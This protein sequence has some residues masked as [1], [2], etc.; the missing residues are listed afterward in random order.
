MNV[1]HLELFYHVARH[2]GVSAAARHMP[3][4]IQQPAI[5]AQILQLED[6][7]GVTLFHRRP[8]K[9]T[10][11]G[12]VLFKY[13]E[14]FFDG[15]AEVGDRLRGA[16]EKRVRIAMPEI[17]QRDYLPA[18]LVRMRKRVPGFQFTLTTGRID[19][20]E[21]ML[22]EQHIDIGFASLNTKRSEDLRS[23]LLIRLPLVL[24]VAKNSRFTRADE[25]I[26]KE[27]IDVPLITI[28]GADPLCRLF[29]EGL[30]KQK[31][32]WFAS[33]EVSSLDIVSRFVAEGFGVGLSVATPKAIFGD[34]VRQIPLRGFPEVE[35][36][37]M[38]LGRLSP[39]GEILLEEAERVARRQGG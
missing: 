6:T 19:E 15:L 23:R 31:V 38:W 17:V 16:A 21:S 39:L 5:S 1:H 9:L 37:A 33:L 7:L 11:E 2:R 34:H 20:I 4:G 30:R 18:V 26:R 3:Y 10:R 27:R 8:F 14:P 25:I 29:Q 22:L 35:F 13:I 28:T 12:N 36:G 24:L 32:D